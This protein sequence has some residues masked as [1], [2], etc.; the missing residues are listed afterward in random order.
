MKSDSSWVQRAENSQGKFLERSTGCDVRK[1]I[2]FAS[3]FNVFKQIFQSLSVQSSIGRGDILTGPSSH[4]NKVG[5]KVAFHL[6]YVG[7][8]T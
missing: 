4:N 7:S 6:M 8:G 5:E 3:N 1:G 2:I